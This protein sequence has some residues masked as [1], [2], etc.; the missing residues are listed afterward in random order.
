VDTTRP[1]LRALIAADLRANTDRSGLAAG[2]AYLVLSPGFLT[3]TL[4]RLAHAALAYG[5][6]G[7]IV[8]KLVWRVSVVLTS[9]HIDR[10][11][12]IG[13][14]LRLPHPTGIVIGETV[15]IGSDVMLFQNVT[16]GTRRIGTS[17]FP[18]LGDGVH[19]YAGATIVGGIKIGD[20]A[21]IGAQCLIVDNVPA[22]AV[23]TAVADD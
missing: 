6:P 15:R 12:V 2:L 17:D 19:V 1:T 21:V 22:G 16:L 23:I 20:N 7:A 10:K 11:A 3:V 5:V 14:G 13:P 8:A 18:E 9:C 4:Y